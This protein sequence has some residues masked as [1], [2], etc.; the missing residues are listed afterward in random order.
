LVSLES[1]PKP[2]VPTSSRNLEFDFPG[3]S[4]GVAEYEEGPTG[5][6]V[7]VFEGGAVF[8]ADVR[9]GSTG[10]I[11]TDYGFARAICFAGGSLMGLEAA[12]GVAAAIYADRGH[13]HV[14]W[15]DVPTVAGAIL[16]DFGA[17]R[18]GIYPDKEL[19]AAAYR[20][21]MP[22]RF[23]MGRHGA[24]RSAGVGKLLVSG[25]RPEPAGQG[26][27]YRQVG[28]T[29]VAVF[30]AVNALGVI[31]DRDGRIVRGNLDPATGE[32]RAPAAALEEVAGPRPGNTTLTLLVTNQRL[33]G[34]GLAQLSRQ[35][36]ASM[37][38]CIQP[39]HTTNDGDVLFAVSTRA[40]QGGPMAEVTRLGI[41]ASELAWDAVLNCFDPA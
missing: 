10:T 1:R 29:K 22:G 18:N 37:G 11:G 14:D 38:R 40:V 24:G 8:A 20:A 17:R 7:F 39:F 27:A 30:V 23:P 2:H 28:D 21:A 33:D 12:S 4:V 31:V 32:R 6:T 3:L 9:G 36:H 13:E 5:C 16:F 26:A 41:V 35:V 19:G 15:N 25:T 34:H